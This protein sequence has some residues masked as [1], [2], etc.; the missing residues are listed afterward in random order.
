M[1]NCIIIG[2]PARVGKTTIARKLRKHLPEYDTFSLDAY[3]S[4]EREAGRLEIWTLEDGFDATCGAFTQDQLAYIELQHTKAR[5]IAVMNRSHGYARCL[6]EGGRSVICEGLYWPQS[7]R[8]DLF[9]SR[10]P[11]A[12]CA[13]VLELFVV[14]NSP[15]LP[16]E[17]EVLRA[18]CEAQPDRWLGRQYAEQGISALLNYGRKQMAWSK[19]ITDYCRVN[20]KHCVDT[21]GRSLE[22]AGG[23]VCSI[24]KG[25]LKKNQNHRTKLMKGAGR[26]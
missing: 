6:L 14:R 1:P 3:T 16:A 20:G 12:N 9:S 7:E 10:H 25:F 8:H 21:S 23:V 26:V 24:V 17:V 4:C 19:T 11:L 13:N 15:D 5:D 22:E 18:V 2:G